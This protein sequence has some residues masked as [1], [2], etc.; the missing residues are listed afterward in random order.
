[1]TA[2]LSLQHHFHESGLAS[3]VLLLLHGTGGDERSLMDLGA[4]IGP[5][6]A[7]LAPRGPVSENGSSRWF[8]RVAE[9][10]F[11]VQDVVARTHQLAEFISEARHAYRLA[12]RRMVAVGFSNGANIAAALT[13]LRPD[14]LDEAVLFASILPL[15][16]V[17]QHD[18]GATKVFLSSGER[19]PQAPLDSVGRLVT[20]YQGRG[21]LV[22]RHCHPGGHLITPAGIREAREWL[23]VSSAVVGT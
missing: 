6:S 22:Q 14:V 18:L 15:D 11:D 4:E 21:A 3:P 23:S 20:A 2:D 10:V 1:M 13:L 17:P 19:D 9:G 12:G 7:L 5:D 8:R 16:E